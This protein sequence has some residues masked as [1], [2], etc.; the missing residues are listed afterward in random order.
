[1][2][3]MRS[4]SRLPIHNPPRTSLAE[5]V[6]P[7]AGALDCGGGEVGV[8]VHPGV[9]ELGESTNGTKTPDPGKNITLLRVIPAMTYQN[10]HV[11]ILCQPDR[12]R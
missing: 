6:S 12:V 2:C 3:G 11:E 7:P 5:P 1:M 9:H 4:P 10:S 8:A